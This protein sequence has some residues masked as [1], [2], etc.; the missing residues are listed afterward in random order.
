MLSHALP[1][2]FADSAEQRSQ[3]RRVLR[4]QA[5]AETPAGEG[6]GIEVHNLSRTGM[7]VESPA[8]LPVGTQLEIA[9]PAGS[10]HRAEVVWTDDRLFGC[11]FEKPLT[12]AQLSAALLRAD[13]RPGAGASDGGD[14]NGALARLH[15][16][17]PPLGEN[18]GAVEDARLPLGQRIWMIGGLATASWSVPVG[19][20][21]L[22]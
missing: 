3:D 11:R 8:G 16:Q 5:Q 17:Y 12:K 7:L 1:A 9:L 21:L 19:A 2:R 13:P 20:W 14:Q 4:L 6:S 22:S 18:T 15:A 10:T